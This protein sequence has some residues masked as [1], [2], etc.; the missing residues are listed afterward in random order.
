MPQAL[1]S[2]AEGSS[3]SGSPWERSTSAAGA[4]S[5][6]GEPSNPCVFSVS[7]SK[8]TVRNVTYNF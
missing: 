3:Q 5:V 2:P 4:Y 8:R 1:L 7:T 6:L